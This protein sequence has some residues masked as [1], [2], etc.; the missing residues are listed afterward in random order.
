MPEAAEKRASV[1]EQIDALS[2]ERRPLIVCDVDEVV[3][4]FIGP[5]EAHM[6]A[7]GFELIDHHYKLTGNIRRIG[8]TDLATQ[9][10]VRA[11]L[12]GFFEAGYAQPLVAGAAEALAAL[13]G[14]AQ[15]VMLTNMPMQFHLR[16]VRAL[17]G[18]G[19]EYPV[20]TNE[21]AKG[22][23]VAALA[24]RVRAP[25]VFLDDSPTNVTSVRDSVPDA[26]L[27]HFM[28]DPRFFARV[29][30][31][32]GVHLTSNDWR[33]ARAFIEDVLG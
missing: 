5:L 24:A 26:Q 18:H 29:E 11:L 13:T 32:P 20:V 22:P 23:A 21:G 6:A 33:A 1:F 19:M 8:G 4:Q 2:L 14:H 31:I 30:R 9:D 12:Y 16:R 25:V 10:D 3:L 15:V 17:A 28:A 27:V 7:H